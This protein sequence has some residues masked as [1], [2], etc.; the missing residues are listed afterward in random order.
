MMMSLFRKVVDLMVKLL[1]PL[2]ILALMIGVA[3]IFIDLRLVYK[4]P[5]ISSGFDIII[6]DILSIF[7]VIELLRSIIEFFE[8]HR[9]RITFIVD[10]T[11]VF[12]MR[13]VMIGI[14]LDKI[15]AKKMCA[16]ALLIAVTGLV[17][18]MAIHYSPDIKKEG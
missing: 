17:R 15:D 14:Y 11:L 4:S 5:T 7:V 9:F 16:F 8:I 2:V 6:T 10:A 1:I 18:T 3:R 12:I 13:E